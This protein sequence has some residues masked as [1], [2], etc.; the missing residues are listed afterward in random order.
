MICNLVDAIYSIKGIRLGMEVFR[1]HSIPL[2]VLS[3]ETIVTTQIEIMGLH[4]ETCVTFTVYR[5]NWGFVKGLPIIPDHSQLNSIEKNTI[6]ILETNGNKTNDMYLKRMVELTLPTIGIDNVILKSSNS[7]ADAIVKDYISGNNAAKVYVL[8]GRPGCGKSTTLRLITKQLSGTLFADYNPTGVHAIS[9]IINQW[10]SDIIIAYD[11]FDV[12]FERI[13]LGNVNDKY[14]GIIPDAKDKAS[15]NSLLDYIKRKQRV[16]F[17]MITNKTFEEIQEITNGDDSFLRYGR[18]DSHFVWPEGDD[19]II[20]IDKKNIENK[21]LSQ[22]E[23]SAKSDSILSSTKKKKWWNV[24]F[25]TIK[26]HS[27]I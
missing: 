18:V 1:S 5:W 7:V 12:S 8:H 2:F 19:E 17:V 16:I 25:K 20:K 9:T 6:H 11:E 26:I 24:S 4:G 10:D 22:I 27:K 21:A 13:V 15:W 23:D 3:W 14:S